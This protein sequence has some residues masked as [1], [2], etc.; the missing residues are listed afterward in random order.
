MSDGSSPVGHFILATNVQK[1]FLKIPKIR[2][3]HPLLRFLHLHLLF[4]LTPH[5][6][7]TR[8]RGAEQTQQ[9]SHTLIHSSIHT[10]KETFFTHSLFTTGTLLRR[11]SWEEEEEKRL[12]HS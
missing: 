7:P 10:K 9:T 11:N 6:T 1:N 8:E 3:P 2:D 4:N 12:T 5:L